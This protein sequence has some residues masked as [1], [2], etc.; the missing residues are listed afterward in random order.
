M[1]SEQKVAVITGASRGIGAGLV[2]GFRRIG[3][4]VI[5]NSRS[6]KATDFG[7]DPAVLAVSG[8]IAVPETAERIVIAAMERFGRIDTL[9]NNAGI[10]I[11]KPFVG[12]TDADFAALVGVHLAGFF[13]LTRRAA[14]RMLHAG[15]GHVVTI[16]TALAEQPM[17]A[18][19]GD[20]VNPSGGDIRNPSTLR[21][22]E[23][24]DG[25]SV[26]RFSARQGRA[27]TSDED[28]G[29]GG[30]DVAAARFGMGHAP[31]CGRGWL[32]PGNGS[33]VCCRRRL[34]AGPGPDACWRA[35]GAHGVGG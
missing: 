20:R 27:E 9:V 22:R 25:G 19:S 26:R 16:T 29:R 8:D 21:S 15:S 13:H 23:K 7:N 11:P 33:A 10:F 2:Q 30:D 28:A 24:Q 12:Y 1:E 17:A 18:V 6:I 3:Y 5:A 32:Q 34:G 4:G 35:G 31:D 14:A